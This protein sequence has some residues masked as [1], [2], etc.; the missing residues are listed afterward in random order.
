[1]GSVAESGNVHLALLTGLFSAVVAANTATK[2]LNRRS[3]AT[4]ARS[5][6]NGKGGQ[7]GMDKRKWVRVGRAKGM[8]SALWVPKGKG[9]PGRGGKLAA[10]SGR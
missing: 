3:G 1:M 5:K 4:L 9:M 2:V 6:W 10:A 8:D 7:S